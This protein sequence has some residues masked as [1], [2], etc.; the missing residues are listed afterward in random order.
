MLTSKEYLVG[1]Y[2]MHRLTLHLVFPSFLAT[3]YQ[4]MKGNAR[5][6]QD[7]ERK[8]AEYGGREG[9]RHD[10]HSGRKHTHIGK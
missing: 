7:E 5:K 8:G 10:G 3:Q 6:D 4:D 1:S 9:G 2:Y